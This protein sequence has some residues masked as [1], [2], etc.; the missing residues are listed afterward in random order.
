[1]RERWMV[2]SEELI[3]W[4]VWWG[5]SSLSLW[6]VASWS[7]TQRPLPRRS[8]HFPLRNG[9]GRYVGWEQWTI[10]WTVSPFEAISDL[11]LILQ[12]PIELDPDPA[13][14]PMLFPIPHHESA[15]A[16]GPLMSPGLQITG[17]WWF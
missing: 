1:M 9:P 14:C 3:A 10:F 4:K 7:P 11:R 13:P 6:A 17:M 5:Q 15:P 2:P 16:Q 8:S 12:W